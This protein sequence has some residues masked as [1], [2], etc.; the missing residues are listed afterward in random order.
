MY[1]LC[2]QS[3]IKEKLTEQMAKKRPL[4][5]PE[6]TKL[7]NGKEN[8]R[9]GGIMSLLGDNVTPFPYLYLRITEGSVRKIPMPGPPSQRI[10]LR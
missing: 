4:P 5:M 6:T 3:D 10:R 2:Q 1:S 8:W 9:S 7:E